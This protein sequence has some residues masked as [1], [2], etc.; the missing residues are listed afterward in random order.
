MGIHRALSSLA[1]CTTPAEVSLVCGI[2]ILGPPVPDGTSRVSILEGPR[3]DQSI[4]CG[5]VSVQNS[6]RWR[7]I[8][9]EAGLAARAVDISDTLPLHLFGRT[10]WYP[11]FGY[12]LG[13][14]SAPIRRNMACKKPPRRGTLR[15]ERQH[16][17]ACLTRRQPVFTCSC[18]K[19]VS[20]DVHLLSGLGYRSEHVP[21]YD[22]DVLVAYT[23]GVVEALNAQQE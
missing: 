5:G 3:G 8:T 13:N 14:C 12:P 18:C 23:D 2:S 10:A 22:G 19:L 17:Q 15:Q 11:S 6:P 20:G 4:L 21:L 9:S 16:Q 7:D 1:G